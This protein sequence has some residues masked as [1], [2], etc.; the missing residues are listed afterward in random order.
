M[1]S[2]SCVR[3]ETKV[4][5][6]LFPPIILTFTIGLGSLIVILARLYLLSNLSSLST[7]SFTLLNYLELVLTTW[8]ILLISLMLGFSIS[9]AL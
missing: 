8:Y 1:L 6:D 5:I 4:F 7:M 3:S 2:H 9:H